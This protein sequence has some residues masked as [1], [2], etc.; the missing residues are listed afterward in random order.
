MLG[1]EMVLV[2]VSQQGVGALVDA[3]DDVT[4]VSAVASAGA[5]VGD[6]FLAMEG[7]GTVSAVTGFDV[8]F[9]VIKKLHV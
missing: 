7:N 1:F 5:S 8:D 2:S 6:V 4:A 9:Y 3:E